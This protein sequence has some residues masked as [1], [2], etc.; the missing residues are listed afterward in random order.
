MVIEFCLCNLKL[1]HT[2]LEVTGQLRTYEFQFNAIG[3]RPRQSIVE[4]VEIN[5]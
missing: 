2:E 3:Y 5:S 4:T 1:S